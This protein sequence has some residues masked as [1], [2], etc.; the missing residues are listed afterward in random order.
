[1]SPRYHCNLAAKTWPLKFLITIPMPN[2]LWSMKI[3]ALVLILTM[4]SDGPFHFLS[5]TSSGFR[6]VSKPFALQNSHW[7]LATLRQRTS[8]DLAFFPYQTS[9]HW[10]HKKLQPIAIMLL[11]SGCRDSNMDCINWSHSHISAN[12]GAIRSVISSMLRTSTVS[13]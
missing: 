5:L 6:M 8:G 10:D 1:M 12:S 9:F 13:G 4:F 11:W 7:A 3:D 2:S